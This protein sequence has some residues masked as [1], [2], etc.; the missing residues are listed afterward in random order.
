M[1]FK[2][3]LLALV[4]GILFAYLWQLFYVLVMYLSDKEFVQPSMFIPLITIQCCLAPM[5]WWI[6]MGLFKV[7]WFTKWLKITATALAFLIPFV[8]IAMIVFFINPTYWHNI[9]FWIINAI[10]SL[11]VMNTLFRPLVDVDMSNF[12]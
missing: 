10:I 6:F 4:C 11:V 5:A 2:K 9:K 3:E 7:T 12:Q 8:V 1:R